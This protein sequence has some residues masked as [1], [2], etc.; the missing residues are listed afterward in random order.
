MSDACVLPFT[1][2]RRPCGRPGCVGLEEA[3]SLS[4]LCAAH[5][6]QLAGRAQLQQQLWTLY[7]QAGALETVL[8]EIDRAARPGV[9]GARRIPF[10][11]DEGSGELI[12]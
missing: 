12:P 4:G 3:S 9:G 2:T 6:W 1:R 5:R 8:A 7:A 10:D 11:G